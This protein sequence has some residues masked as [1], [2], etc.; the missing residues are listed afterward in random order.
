MSFS[1]LAPS[2]SYHTGAGCS[3]GSLSSEANVDDR[4]KL[5]LYLADLAAA[6]DNHNQVSRPRPGPPRP[7]S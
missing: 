5:K 6:A 7:S 1:W 3:M 4:D 2:L